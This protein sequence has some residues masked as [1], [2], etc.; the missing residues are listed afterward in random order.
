[1]ENKKT[2]KKIIKIS[3]LI[4]FVSLMIALNFH[5]QPKNAKEINISVDSWG[6]DREEFN[7]SFKV[8]DDNTVVEIADNLLTGTLI[9]LDELEGQPYDIET[10]DWNM[11]FSDSPST[12]Q[13]HLQSLTAIVYLTKAFEING[14]TEYLDLAKKF[15]RE[16]DEYRLSNLA[17]GNS[18]VWYDHGT[19]LRADNII[20][21]VLA[22]EKG[23][24]DYFSQDE[25]QW[26]Y[27]LLSEHAEFL[28]NNDN[29][30][31]NHNHGI[32][33][34]QALLYCAYFLNN[35]KK[36]EW[37]AIAEER[38]QQQ[39]EYAFTS[40]MVH[41]E[42][43]P[44][45]Q[46]GV[47]ELFRVVAEF[48][49]QFNDSYSNTLYTDIA[50][51]AEF[52]AY[53]MKP[54]GL[55]AEI[56]DTNSSLETTSIGNSALSVFGN[57]YLTYAATKGNEGKMPTETSAIYPESGYYLSR[58]SWEKDN[59]DMATWM[60][61]KSGY[62]SKTHKHADDNSFML[63]SRGM[64]IFV[65]PGW[66]NYI[67]GN[68]Y[69][70]YFVSSNAHNTVIVDG[71]TY[72]PTVENS[73]KTGIYDY[74]KGENYDYVIGYNEMYSGVSFDRHFYNLGDAIVIYDN[75]V[76][77]E[78]HTY[79]Q[80]FHASEHM[81]VMETSEYET[82]FALR[83]EE[84]YFV[85]VSQMIKNG[86]NT[87]IRG[88]KENEKFGYISRQMNHLD[89]I[90]TLKYDVKG[91]SVDIITLI[92]IE[93]AEGNIEG[94][95]DISYSDEG[96]I[97]VRKKAGETFSID[98]KQRERI[99][100][101]KVS[102]EQKSNDTY[103][104][105]NENISDKNSYAWYI[106]DKNSAT[107]VFKSNYDKNPVFEYSFD[108]L[109]DSEY[110]VK[111]YTRSENGRYRCSNIIADI[112]YDEKNNLWEDVTEEYPNLNLTYRGQEHEECGNNAYRFKVNIDY[113]WNYK[114]LWYIYKG[115][116]Y[117]T[118]FV[119]ENQ[120]VME[121]EFTEPGQYTVMYYLTTSNGDNEFWNF[122]EIKIE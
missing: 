93:D 87:I 25:M 8:P 71:K 75:I 70:D 23:N 80:L 111:A 114:I 28:A 37:I 78:N 86:S 18:F 105:T 34:D 42:N 119:T 103:I 79:S 97:N 90:D 109:T 14:K 73:T 12:F 101:D 95:T 13:L 22:A 76:S 113:S 115:G 3:I 35:E 118:S 7:Y 2:S 54:N 92:T 39:K 44:G 49:N 45:Y 81:H 67:T 47:M 104:F 16:W 53:V 117:F 66:Y 52:M 27:R 43:S 30:T 33:Q 19:A 55:V 11:T 6:I 99:Y 121:Y 69:R 20:Y 107:P 61:F 94:I 63:Y 21:F 50:E 62:V 102:V 9:V 122:N 32:F 58:N 83:T 108:T 24:K 68:R 41:V 96:K 57:D 72:S 40:E 120:D 48:L 1:M 15:M 36:N 5:N 110:L 89:T 65:D 38:L 29:Y 26:I 98:L 106:I 4:V 31:E 60:M 51:S 10:I 91:S 17:E 56:G 77:E 74:D 82:L 100:A 116:G 84:K 112:R 59:F 64:D 88:D 46:T 85:R